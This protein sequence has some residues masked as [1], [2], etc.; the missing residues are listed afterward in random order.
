MT[1]WPAAPEPAARIR[2]AGA[3]DLDL[4]ARW[5]A[6]L[7]GHL[8]ATGDPYATGAELEEADAR[9]FVA[10]AM[11]L[12]QLLLLAE[13][14]GMPAGFLYGRCE[15]PFIL[16]SPIPRIGHVSIVYVEPTAR[17][18]GVARALLAAAEARFRA[19]GCPYV[20]LSYLA[21]NREAEAAWRELGFTPFRVH[22]RKPLG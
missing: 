4:L 14:D 17:R 19:Q 9:R 10:E 18:R 12:G 7:I 2:L 15:K 1:A 20:Q 3:E 16:E 21:G 5:A 11:D 8:A 13:L 6:A 22:A